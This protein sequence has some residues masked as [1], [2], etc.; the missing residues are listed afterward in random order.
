MAEKMLFKIEVIN[1]KSDHVI[2][3]T[4]QKISSGKFYFFWDKRVYQLL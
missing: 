2:N 1:K 3:N 4:A